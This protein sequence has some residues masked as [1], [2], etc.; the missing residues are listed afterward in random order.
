LVRFTLPSIPAGCKINTA[1]LRLFASS[2]TSGR[3]LQAWQVSASWVENTVTW[4]TRP[5][6]TGAAATTA[7]GN[8]YI[9]W[10]VTSI[11][12]AMYSGTNNGFLIRDAV[13]DASGNG[14]QQQFISR[15]NGSPDKP[16]LVL[17][18]TQAP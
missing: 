8:G 7:A 10:T 16:Q 15:E 9:Q 13:E 1:T 14:E 5:S 3:T 17:T 12:Q 4:D 6:I 18:Y 11:V 2:S